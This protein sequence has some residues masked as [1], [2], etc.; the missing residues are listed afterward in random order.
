M[1]SWGS[2][3][4]WSRSSQGPLDRFVGT[5]YFK[6]FSCF[7]FCIVSFGFSRASPILWSRRD[8]WCYFL[9]IKLSWTWI[10]ESKTHLKVRISIFGYL[11]SPPE[12]YFVFPGFSW[13]LMASR[14]ELVATR[15]QGKGPA[16]VSRPKACQNARFNTALEFWIWVSELKWEKFWVVG[17]EEI[18]E[19]A[20]KREKKTFRLGGRVKGFFFFF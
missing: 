16:K 9:L 17:S 8:V 12:L 10:Y 2:V 19:K 14:W 11:F 13:T 7:I 4:I 1:T 15:A 18:W 3:E 20:S 5:Q 6:S